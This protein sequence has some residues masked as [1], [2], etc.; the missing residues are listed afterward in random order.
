MFGEPQFR[1][2]LRTEETVW[3]TSPL[4]PVSRATSRLGSSSRR[5]A[6]VGLCTCRRTTK[7]KQ[8]LKL[9]RYVVQDDYP[10]SRLQFRVYEDGVP[11]ARRHGAYWGYRRFGSLSSAKAWVEERS[12]S[13]ERV[14][15]W[16]LVE[17][18]AEHPANSRGTSE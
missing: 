14:G 5:K 12:L 4:S 6:E 11:L 7:N 3:A 15:G 18:L 2:V 8:S 1:V 17:R 10:G 9:G 16:L 13:S